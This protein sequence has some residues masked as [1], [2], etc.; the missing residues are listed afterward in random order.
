[1]ERWISALWTER[2]IE[3]AKGRGIDTAP[4]WNMS[5]LAPG[6]PADARVSDAV[7]LALW[8]EVIRQSDAS[9]AITY[10]RSMRLDD[11]EAL[12]LACKTAE[13]LGAA[14]ER[15]ARYLALWTNAVDFQF[16]QEGESARVVLRRA[17]ATTPGYRAAMESSV[18]ELA[19]SIRSL[20]AAPI[21][22]STVSFAHPAPSD[23]AAHREH[24]QC[25]LRFNATEYSI[26]LPPSSLKTR[27]RLADPGLSQ[28]MLAH[29]EE[30][31]AAAAGDASLLAD[32]GDAISRELPSGP[33]HV[34]RVAARLGLSPRT[35]Q[36]RLRESETSFQT[37]VTETRQ[38]LARQMLLGTTHS[39]P[40]IGFLLGFSEPSAFHRAF[41]RWFGVTPAAFRKSGGA[42][43]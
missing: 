8:D 38:V 30:R 11:Y 41:R 28:F 19:S 39:L 27:L 7:H 1:M 33:P 34:K 4:L 9:F 18:A 37:V 29:L 21:D 32:V 15:L 5:G 35:L 25:K 24:F 10:A 40:E 16:E 2:L 6:S 20:A 36:R 23:L 42:L 26:A 31:A 17:G 3:V 22:M 12:G 14:L 13:D 43:P